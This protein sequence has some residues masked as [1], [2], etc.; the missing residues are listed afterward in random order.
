MRKDAELPIP[1]TARHGE[2]SSRTRG[3]DRVTA[4][5][6]GAGS[7]PTTVEARKRVHNVRLGEPELTDGWVNGRTVVLAG[8]SVITMG[9]DG[10]FVIRNDRILAVG[11]DAGTYSPDDALRIDA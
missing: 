4:L 8:A 7:L 2:N 6:C 5:S 11:V 3:E 10:D 9:P 1:R